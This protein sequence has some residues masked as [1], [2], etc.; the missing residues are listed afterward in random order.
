M[1]KLKFA[2]V[3]ALLMTLVIPMVA[4]GQSI[5]Y[6][7]GIQ[8]QNLD[9]SN[10]ANITVTYYN[11]DGSTAATVNDTI[12]AGGSKTYFPL[13]AVSD[14]FNGS[15]V[16]SSDR[17]IRAI[18]N[19]L[20]N[21]GA[22]GASY[23][24]FTAGATT[25]YVP[26]L[27]KENSGYSTWFNVQNTGSD[28]TN[29]SVAYSDGVSASCS[30]LQPGA[31]CTLDQTSEAHAAGWVGSAEVTASQPVAVT[32]M[33]VGPTTL[34]AYTGF[35]GGSTE[36]VM[37]LVNANN[38]GYITGIQIMNQGDAS[39]SVTVSY[40]P[41]AAGTA[42]AETQTIPA[43]QSKTFALAAFANGANSTCTGGARFIGSAEVTANSASQNLVAIVNQLNPGA[44]KGAAYE[45]FDPNSATDTVVMPL[46]MD[47]NSN[48]FTGFSVMNVGGSTTTVNCTFS[49]TS[50]TL[51]RSLASGEAMTVIQNGEIASG[52]VG[53][54]T[55]TAGS[56]GEIVG[57]VNELNGVASG[58]A[59]LV[60]SSFNK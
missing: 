31:A 22:Y 24:G 54:A 58:D 28:P 30:N 60:Y 55:C 2:L 46:I 59:F 35:T 42:C 49:G 37:P 10:P 32:A 12:T 33:E 44:N 57:I 48:Y 3:I 56:G 23:G 50:Y 16:I 38:A 40:T 1:K 7:A 52:Y 9:T 4:S 15:V 8:M 21:G 17:E 36:V 25:A 47:R 13:S 41:S 53:S 29:V 43:K 19:I 39:T 45:G 26:L 6:T 34:F 5:V 11:Q 14:G 51:S 27:M 18:G 20:G